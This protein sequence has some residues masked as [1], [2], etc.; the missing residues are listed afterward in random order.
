[1]ARLTPDVTLELATL[2]EYR[3]IDIVLTR[4]LFASASA[5]KFSANCRWPHCSRKH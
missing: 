4:E 2:K 1:V 3:S 5:A